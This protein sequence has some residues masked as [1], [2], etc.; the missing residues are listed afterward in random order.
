MLAAIHH[1]T[2]DAT[3][4]VWSED[5]HRIGLKPIIR[6]V[7]CKKGQR[8]SVCVQHRYAWCYVYGFVCPQ[9]GKNFWLVLPKVSIEAW[10][11]ALSEFA[12]AMELSSHKHIVLVIDR[13]GWHTSQKVTV[14]E[15]LHLV[16]LPPYSPELQPAERLWS[17]SDEALVNKHFTDLDA[18]VQAQ[19]E[20]CRILIDLPEIIRSHTF[21]HWWP[22]LG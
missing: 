5:E 15:G 4:E 6:R 17:L 10:N 18:L 14:P 19:T 7:W 9:S 8:P 3:I 2:P 13:A 16:C 21:F 20:R 22:T 11:A 1:D 12:S